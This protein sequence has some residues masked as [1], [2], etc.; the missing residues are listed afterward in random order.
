M[1]VL[2]GR[3]ETIILDKHCH[4]NLSISNLRM[5]RPFI[6][7]F[8]REVVKLLSFRQAYD[9]WQDQPGFLLFLLEIS[10]L[11]MARLLIYSLHGE[12]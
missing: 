10:S 11:R 8:A 9:Y 5:A 2:G 4:R 3:E 12:W 7:S 1:S 6:N